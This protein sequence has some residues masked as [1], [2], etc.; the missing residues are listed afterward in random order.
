MKT[1][2]PPLPASGPDALIHYLNLHS[3][4]LT[5]QGINV[6]AFIDRLNALK[7]DAKPTGSPATAK[8]KARKKRSRN[9]DGTS[10]L[11]PLINTSL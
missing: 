11:P 3:A 10:A 7:A 1:P 2:L 5:E 6:P 9:R 8:P 4:I